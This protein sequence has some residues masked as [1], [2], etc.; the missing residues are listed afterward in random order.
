MRT[1]QVVAVVATGAC[2]RSAVPI[3]HVD[4]A[5]GLPPGVVAQ[6][7]HGK[8]LYV[9]QCA[10][11]HGAA[12]GG[13]TDR[14]PAIVGAGALPQQPRSGSKR[15]AVFRTA[16]DVVDWTA[17]NMPSD[18]PASL[19]ADQYLAIVAF[20]LVAN[21][22]RLDVPLDATSAGAIVLHRLRRP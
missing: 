3:R 7:D 12:G 22:I 19:S 6:V 16:A 10:N 15:N 11:C 17:E 14:G 4:G 5:S 13:L 21:G 1:A 18:A 20:D 2:H 9:E 8:Q